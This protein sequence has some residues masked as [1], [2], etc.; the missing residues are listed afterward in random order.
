MVFCPTAQCY[1]KWRDVQICG[2]SR[3]SQQAQTSHGSR[4]RKLPPS[5]DTIDDDSVLPFHFS[6]TDIR[7]RIARLSRTLGE[8]LD[9]RNYPS[10]VEPVIAETA[11][12]TA[13]MG[14]LINPG[15]K[16]SFQIR[17]EGLLR[18]VVSDY[19]VSSAD[20]A[21][22]T[23]RVTATFDDGLR[24]IPAIPPLNA[25]KG[26]LAVL[27]DDGQG[28]P[29]YEGVTSLDDETVAGC[30][31]NLFL[32]SEQIP[33]CFRVCVGRSNG[34]GPTRWRGG[35]IALQC[36]PRGSSLSAAPSPVAATLKSE[37][38]I[39]C[40]SLL[41]TA[42]PAELTGPSCSQLETVYR[43]F[44]DDEPLAGCP[45]AIRFG[46]TCSREK[47]QQGLSI[48]SAKDIATMTNE[49]GLVIADCHFCG[50][51]YSLDPSSLGMDA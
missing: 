50:A 19:F 15:S 32:H 3:L 21:P 18:L 38:W 34:T 4:S 48:Y 40:T 46:C 22:A 37:E 28:G 30:A 1:A 33:T 45:Q 20:G 5:G 17:S 10:S 24:A 6:R 27:I 49:Q 12:L 8:L 43:L 42:K 39:R 51:R 26:Y 25:V 13:L 44:H 29:P 16:L 23:L 9:G 2:V 35:G 7:G 36:I 41:A 11:V 47:V 31:E 14:Q